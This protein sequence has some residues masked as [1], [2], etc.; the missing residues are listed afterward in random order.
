VSASSPAVSVNIGPPRSCLGCPFEDLADL[1]VVLP[2]GLLGHACA[3]PVAEH[4]TL[5]SRAA[6]MYLPQPRVHLPVRVLE[7]TEQLERVVAVQL[8][9]HRHGGLGGVLMARSHA[10]IQAAIPWEWIAVLK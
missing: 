9:R 10:A 4:E 2:V 5:C 7:C 8:H 1:G 3:S 6:V